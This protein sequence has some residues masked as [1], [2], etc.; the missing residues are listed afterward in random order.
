[1]LPSRKVKMVADSKI[2]DFSSIKDKLFSKTGTTALLVIGILGIA[3]IALTS[4]WPS[5]DKKTSSSSSNISTAEYAKQ[6]ESQLTNIVGHI[7]GVGRVQVMVT[8]ESG[9]QYVYEQNQKDT[10]DTTTSSSNDGDM[11][12]QENTGTEQNPVIMENSSGGQ[13]ALIK[14][15]LQPAIKGVVV[16]CDGGDNPVVQENVV[17][18]V[19]T[20]LDVPSN[21][22]SVSKMSPK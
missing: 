1:M 19:T 8:V 11:Q 4:F 12:K 3:L 9:V 13:Q 16:V 10:N 2:L 22:I 21:H 5:S 18:T 7:D 17:S 20:A 14:T 15:E 6:I